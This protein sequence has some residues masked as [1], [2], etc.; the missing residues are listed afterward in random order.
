MTNRKPLPSSADIVELAA[1]DLDLRSLPPEEVRGA[2]NQTLH[3]LME[4]AFVIYERHEHGH[5][6]EALPRAV[7]DDNPDKVAEAEQ[8]GAIQGFKRGVSSL[9]TALYPDLRR[10][11]LSI[12]QGRKSRGGKSFEDQF[13]LLL[14]LAGFNYE[15]QHRQLRTDFILPSVGGFEHNRTVCAVASLKRTLRERWQEVAGELRKLNSPN[16]FLV[17]ADDKVSSGHVK[18]ICDDHMLH[19]VVWDEVKANHA[20]HPRVLGFTQFANQRLPQLKA[21]WESEGLR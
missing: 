3:R 21:M 4:R 8:V 5:Y 10:A 19:L 2:F 18:G 11:F 16:V 7:L 14:T 6:A 1:H 12:G 20:A 9:L 17:T 15:R 13:A